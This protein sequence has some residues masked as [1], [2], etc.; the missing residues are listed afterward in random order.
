MLQ[1]GS[2]GK[3]QLDVL[4]I[5]IVDTPPVFEYHPFRYIDFKEQT[6]IRKWAAQRTAEHIP[7]CGTEFFMDFGF[8]QSLT[9]DYKRPNKL[10]DWVVNSYDGYSV[11]LVI[12]DGAS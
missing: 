7:T 1:F 2:P 4:L 9:E 12:V 10:T 11:H 5:H 3:C 8:M 6:Y